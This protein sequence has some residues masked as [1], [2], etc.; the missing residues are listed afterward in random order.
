[1]KHSK[2]LFPILFLIA[3]IQY[4]Q[5]LYSYHSPGISS[6]Q[7]SRNLNESGVIKKVYVLPFILRETDLYTLYVLVNRMDIDS[8]KIKHENPGLY[9]SGKFNTNYIKLYN[10]GTHG[11]EVA[12][13]SIFTLNNISPSPSEYEWLNKNDFLT[14]CVSYFNSMVEG[15]IDFL[16]KLSNGTEFRETPAGW[17]TMPPEWVDIIH[18]KSSY[19]ANL[20]KVVQVSDEIFATQYAV[21]IIVKP[22]EIS[23][24]LNLECSP[25]TKKFYSKF[26]DDYDFLIID[27]NHLLNSE[28]PF[29]MEEGIRRTAQFLKTKDYDSGIVNKELFGTGR[30]FDRNSVVGSAG[31]LKGI[32]HIESK[33]MDNMA[34]LNHEIMHNWGIF[35]KDLGTGHYSG[36]E[37]QGTAFGGQSNCNGVFTKIENIKDKTYRLTIDR[38]TYPNSEKFNDLELYLAGFAGIDEVAFPIK[39]LVNASPFRVVSYGNISVFEC[40]ADSLIY[41]TKDKLLAGLGERNPDVSQSQKSFKMCMII[42]SYKQLSD[43]EFSFY[44]MLMRAYEKQQSPRINEQDNSITFY[45]ATRTKASINTNVIGLPVSVN[46]INDNIG[47]EFILEQNYPNPFNPTTKIKYGLPKSVHVK[48]VIYDILGRTVKV[49]VNEFQNSGFYELNFNAVNLP[50]GIYYYRIQADEYSVTKKFVLLK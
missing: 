14:S 4:S 10:D 35:I 40:E 8:L 22:D 1:M 5:N 16:I 19:P 12:G 23:P 37:Y 32:I 6:H 48:L 25:V 44:D 9:I 36:I 2:L 33:A 45:G 49:L 17:R 47:S 50:S 15:Q 42:P 24:M 26:G 13:D 21:N 43:V 31:K 20:P 38:A 41:I 11:D 34:A 46:E 28:I 39:S 3:S 7:Y 18:M 29:N 27:L 30:I